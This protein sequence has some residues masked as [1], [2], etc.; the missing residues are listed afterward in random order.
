MAAL[1]PAPQP[2]P[3]WNT[4]LAEWGLVLLL[5]V[6]LGAVLAYQVREMRGQAELAQIKSTLGALR[7]ALVVAHLEAAVGKG[8]TGGHAVLPAQSNPFTALQQP[9]ANYA[10]LADPQALAVLPGGS[11]V[12]DPGCGCIGYRPSEA[13]WLESPKDAGALWFRVGAST[14]PT[15]ITAVQP[16]V[17]MGQ[18]VD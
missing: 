15:Q 10:G 12:F 7:T 16:Y 6:A 8:R 3:V 9:P 1:R 5:V 4:R 17:W 13:A 11:W 18:A 14:G 2:S